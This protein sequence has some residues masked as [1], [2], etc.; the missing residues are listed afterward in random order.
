MDENFNH[1]KTI[2]TKKLNFENNIW[3]ID[4]A[5]IFKD[6]NSVEEGKNIKFNSHFNYEKINNL[7]SNLS[8]ITMLGL[9]KLKKIMI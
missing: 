2:K 8:S 1:L 4:S 3:E 9:F 6:N 5:K 7:Y